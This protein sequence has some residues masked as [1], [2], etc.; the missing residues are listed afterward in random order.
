[1]GD[2]VTVSGT[3]TIYEGKSGVLETIRGEGYY[4]YGVKLDG[5]EPHQSRRWFSPGELKEENG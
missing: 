2:R 5:L 3:E 4:D 1:M